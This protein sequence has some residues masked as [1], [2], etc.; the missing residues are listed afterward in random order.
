MSDTEKY[1]IRLDREGGIHPGD[2][3]AGKLA[4]L[5]RVL[6]K[7]F[8][9]SE[10]DF[11]L[12]AIEDNCIRLD[13]NIRSAKVKAAIALF[14]AFLVGQAV[15]PDSSVLCNLGELDRVRAKFAG[16]SMTFPAVNGIQSV[17]IPPDRRLS[18]MVKTKPNIHFQHTIYGKV[19]DAG[20]E[21]PNIH[22]RPLGGGTEII[23]DCSEE[24]ASEVA[25]LL[26]S[27]VGIV[28][29]VTRSADPIRMKA[30]ALLPYRKP[31]RNPFA[32]LKE[33]GASQY[34][35][36]ESVEDFMRKVRGNDGDG[37]A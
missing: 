11:C 27:V 21:H 4:E 16:V 10:D 22:I 2:I 6:S 8:A 35:E 37:N 5:L 15:A 12:A 18:D 24:L 31:T 3:P 34:F 20:G 19:M 13:F 29:E 9:D 7:Q 23:C 28:G 36:S 30:Q 33:A 26:Y 25:H 14:A 17:T 32:I 1:S